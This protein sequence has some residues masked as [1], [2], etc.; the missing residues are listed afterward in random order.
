MLQQNLQEILKG[1]VSSNIALGIFKYSNQTDIVIVRIQILLNIFKVPN[2]N[3]N[4]I[5]IPMSISI[6]QA[7]LLGQFYAGHFSCLSCQCSCNRSAAATH[8]QYL[9]CFVHGHPINNILA[10]IRQMV[11]KRPIVF[12]FNNVHKLFFGVI[13]YSLQKLQFN[14]AVTIKI[15]SRISAVIQRYF[16]DFFLHKHLHSSE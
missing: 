11:E 6:N 10:Q 8:L 2:M 5:A 13:F 15:L 9:C 3:G 14:L 12:F 16:S 7:P 4:I 1:S